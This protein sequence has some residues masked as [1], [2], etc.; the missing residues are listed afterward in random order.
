MIK[1]S[2]FFC[3]ILIRILLRSWFLNFSGIQ[4]KIILKNYF[5]IRVA[6]E[7]IRD[8]LKVKTMGRV[9]WKENYG[10]GKGKVR[11]T[12]GK[13]ATGWIQ[14]FS[15]ESSSPNGRAN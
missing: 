5:I 13:Y 9:E 8:F 11:Q 4:H 7:G 2:P 12:V 10:N 14:L 15:K 1:V 3:R 6:L